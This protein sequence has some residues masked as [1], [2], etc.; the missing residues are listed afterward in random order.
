MFKNLYPDE[1]LNG[2]DDI[3]LEM[4]AEQGIKGIITDVDNTIV[5]HGAPADEHAVEWFKRSAVTESILVS[6]LTMTNQ[7]CNHLPMPLDQNIFTTLTNLA[8]GITNV[9]WN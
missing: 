8:Q 6:F 4:Y 5:P 9:L 2:I 3:D 7:E 1:Y